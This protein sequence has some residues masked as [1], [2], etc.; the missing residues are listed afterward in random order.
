MVGVSEFGSPSGVGATQGSS[1]R[2]EAPWL[3]VDAGGVIVGRISLGETQTLLVVSCGF[4]LHF[5]LLRFLAGLGLGHFVSKFSELCASSSFSSSLSVLTSEIIPSASMTGD[6]RLAVRERYIRLLGFD[7][8][9]ASVMLKRVLGIF[10][11][12]PDISSRSVFEKEVVMAVH[13]GRATMSALEGA[14]PHT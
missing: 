7:G 3:I 5:G 14:P 9:D 11:G 4:L 12:W 13:V 6:L 10:R 1:V 2:V 8:I